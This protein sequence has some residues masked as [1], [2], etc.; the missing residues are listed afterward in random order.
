L[1]L[2]RGD[3]E[4]ATI[5]AQQAV[6]LA[7]AGQE[8]LEIGLALRILGHAHMAQND[9]AAAERELHASLG[10]LDSIGSRVEAANTR[11]A[12]A[13]LRQRQHRPEEAR[14]LIQTAV[15]TYTAAGAAPLAAQAQALSPMGT[16]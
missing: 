12:L 9:L 13:Q 15:E 6:T 5:Q 14:Q 8:K 1:S 4:G 16:E 10:V 7:E 2:G 3:I 11:T